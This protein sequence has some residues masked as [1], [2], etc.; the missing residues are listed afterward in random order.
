MWLVAAGEQS[1]ATA[2]RVSGIDYQE[3]DLKNILEFPL[4]YYSRRRR[5]NLQWRMAHVAHW[6]WVAVRQ[7]KGS[8]I[9][10]MENYCDPAV[11]L[12]VPRV[13]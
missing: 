6:P 5:K 8:N 1:A 3:G 11:F 2:I 7:L 4:A 12:G 10:I 9:G 13:A